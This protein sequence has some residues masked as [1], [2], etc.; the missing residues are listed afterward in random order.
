METLRIAVDEMHPHV[1]E[2]ELAAKLNAIKPQL[3]AIARG[4]VNSREEAEDIYQD[5]V[6]K[7]L[8]AQQTG[9]YREDGKFKA[10]VCQI[11][12]NHCTDQFRKSRNFKTVSNV[13]EKDV[14]EFVASKE[15]HADEPIRKAQQQDAMNRLIDKLPKDQREVVVMRIYLDLPFNEIAD[16]TGVSINTALGRMRYALINLRKMMG[17]S[18]DQTNTQ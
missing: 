14:F 15:F 5:V 7:V 9:T 10:W 11:T 12:R 3:M 2:G 8:A 1:R 13:F 17:V 4:Y 16:I 6:M 18:I